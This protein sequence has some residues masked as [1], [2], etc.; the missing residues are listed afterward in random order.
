MI[1][2]IQEQ[3][4]S[5]EVMLEKR[6]ALLQTLEGR[7]EE[8]QRTIAIETLRSYAPTAGRLGMHKLQGELEEL[9][10]RYGYPEE[11]RDIKA[12]IKEAN[13][14][15]L[16]L[17]EIFEEPICE[18]LNDLGIKYEFRYRMKSAYSI[19]QKMRRQHKRFDQIYDLFAARIIYKVPNPD[20]EIKICWQIYDVITSIY[21]VQTD[22]IKDWVT[23]PKPS[24]Y[25]SLQLTCMGPERTWVELQIRSERMNYEAEHG[26]AAHWKYKQDGD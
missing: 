20:D 19:W 11:Y 25:Q 10:M 22:R 5:S 17:F 2:I 13:D 3:I 23:K 18:A 7:S 12:R 15:C 26:N 24:G 21:R 9:G 14:N 6:L 8:E 4:T 16:M 1:S